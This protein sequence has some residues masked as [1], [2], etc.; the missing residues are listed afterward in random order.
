MSHRVS[1]SAWSTI[2]C[3][4][5]VR[6]HDLREVQYL[7]TIKMQVQHATIQ[8]ETKAYLPFSEFDDKRGYAGFYPS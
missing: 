6:E 2:L 7:H 4:M 1:A 3:E 5:H 8:N